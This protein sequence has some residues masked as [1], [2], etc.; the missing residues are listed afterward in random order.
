MNNT[1]NAAETLLK[2]LKI[3][4]NKIRNEEKDEVQ[5]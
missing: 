1:V 3:N 4:K 5:N 2:A